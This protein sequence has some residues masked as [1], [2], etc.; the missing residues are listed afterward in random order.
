MNTKSA[1]A[2]LPKEPTPPRDEEESEDK[3]VAVTTRL[4]GDP[5]TSHFT[6]DNLSSNEGN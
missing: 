4:R 5:L 6:M 1:K 2:S 3:K